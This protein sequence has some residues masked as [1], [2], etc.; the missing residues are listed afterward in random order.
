MT[1]LAGLERRLANRVARLAKSDGDFAC[2]SQTCNGAG[3]LRCRSYSSLLPQRGFDVGKIDGVIG[4]S[5]R[6][7]IRAIQLKYALPAD[8]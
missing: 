2:G 3:A 1:Q 6:Q 7:A 8:G 5:T 4:A